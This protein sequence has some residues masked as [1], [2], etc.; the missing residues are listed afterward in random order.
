M[1]KTLVSKEGKSANLTF[2]CTKDE[3]AKT[4]IEAYQ[5]QHY[6]IRIYYKQRIKLIVYSLADK[7]RDDH[8]LDRKSVV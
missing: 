3:F 6:Y 7:H 2:E 4:C 5:N 1:K 8:S